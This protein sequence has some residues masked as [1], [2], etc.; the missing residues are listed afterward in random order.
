MMFIDRNLNLKKIKKHLKM[1]IYSA[2]S[3]RHV[4]DSDY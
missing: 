1:D 3:V 2:L 4:S